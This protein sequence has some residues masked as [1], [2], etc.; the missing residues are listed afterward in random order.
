MCIR[1]RQ[2]ITAV[3]MEGSPRGEPGCWEAQTWE[4]DTLPAELLPLGRR[5]PKPC[6]ED[7]PP[8]PSDRRARCPKRR[9]GEDEPTRVHSGSVSSAPKRGPSGPG[10]AG[11]RSHK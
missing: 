4:A 11:G 10:K 2:R 7:L 6:G 9:T 1:D 5:G 3:E 8:P